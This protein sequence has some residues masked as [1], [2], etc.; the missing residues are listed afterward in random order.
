MRKI[1]FVILSVSLIIGFCNIALCQEKEGKIVRAIEVKGNKAVSEATVISKVKV[2]LGDTF[3]QRAID[4][5]LKRLYATGYFSD[6]SID[7]QD[8]SDGVKVIFILKERVVIEDIIIEGNRRIRIKKIRD[9]LKSKIGDM[10][11]LAILNQDINEVKKLYEEKGFQLANI[12]YTIDTNKE[13]NTAKIH[14]RIDEGKRIK[15]HRIYIEGNSAFPYKKIISIMSTR[16][17]F[18]FTSGI[19]K[20]DIFEEDLE[21]IKQLYDD[22]GYLDV[23]IT[24]DLKYDEKNFMYITIKIDEGKKYRVG[25]I[26]LKG[27]V[28]FPAPRLRENIKMISGKTFSHSGLRT[29]LYALQDFYFRYGYVSAQIKA[30]TVLNQQTGNIDITYDIVENELSYVDR[31]DIRGNTRTKDKVIRR[32][33]RIAPG[34]IF[35]GDKLKRSKERL[36]NLGYFEDISYDIEPGSA[37]NKK[38]L[39]VNIKET[40]TGEFSFGGGWSSIDQ[41]IGFVSVE[42]KNFDLFNFPEFTGAGQRI[43]IR[44]E[45]GT[46]RRDYGFSFTEPWIFNFPLSAGFDVYQS[47]NQKSRK[48]GYGYDMVRTGEDFRIGKEFGD[49]VRSDVMFKMERIKISGISDE[50]TQD[51]KDEQGATNVHT[52]SFDIIRD[53]RDNI[54]NPSSGYYITGGVDCAGGIFSGDK[55]FTRY[56]A[57]AAHYSS[58]FGKGVLE[59]KV[60]AG[61]IEPFGDSNKVPIYE[62]FFAGGG[63]TIRGYKERRVGPE[64]TTSADPIGGG[65]TFIANAEYTFPIIQVIKGAVFFDIG[66]VWGKAGDLLSGGFKSGFGFGVRVK[67]PLGPVK[68]DYGIPLNKTGNEKKKGQFYFSMSHGF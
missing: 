42:Q 27:N 45:F 2:K 49:Y 22:A 43:T 47:S 15:V 7:V 29:D 13:T 24:Y 32:E 20:E 4:D 8:Y 30:D 64:D 18:L 48:I 21:K 46:V 6:V 12:D 11:D 31:I 40:K 50:A 9:I 37:P 25:D 56:T 68:L 36:Y 35:N 66:N 44:G 38:D 62:R 10:L 41:L 53:T 57:S 65:A 5:D 1:L 52:L 3:S 54:F 60:R 39:I 16:R 19:F 59:L 28:I 14:I 23:K 61:H 26:A 67:T 34:Q 63:D 33:L 51:L 58:W 55:D 17:D